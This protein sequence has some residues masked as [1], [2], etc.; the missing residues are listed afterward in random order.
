MPESHP[1]SAK[2]LFMSRSRRKTSERRRL[3][4]PGLVMA[5]ALT[6]LAAAFLAP[7][8]AYAAVCTSTQPSDFNGDGYSDAAV[9]DPYATVAGISQAGRVVVLYGDGDGRIGEGER[10]SVRQGFGSVVGAPETSDRFG[11]AIAIADINGDGCHDLVVGSPYENVGANSDSGLVQVV[12][13]DPGG[14]GAGALSQQLTQ[15][16]FGETV[17]AGDQFGYAV[18][19]LDEVYQ[20]GTGPPDAYALGIGAPGFDVA[21]HNDAGW[22][23]FVAATD[24]G[25]VSMDATQNTP[26]IPG[27]A[28][29]GDRFGSAISIGYLMGVGDTVDAAVGVPGE[30]V[31]A[32]VDAGSVTILADVYDA[33]VAGTDFSQN[34]PGVAS[35]AE[36]GDKFG[37]SLDTVEAAPDTSYL[38][39]GVPGE[40]VGA[41]ANA[42]MVQVFTTIN[43]LTELVP[44]VGLSQDSPGVTGAAE[45]GDLFGQD[46]EFAPPGPGNNTTRLAIS[47]PFEDGTKVNYGAIWIFP[48]NNLTGETTYSQSSTGMPGGASDG[49]RFGDSLAVVQGESETALLI[50]V[51]NDVQHSHGMVNVLPFGGAN[52]RAWIPGIDGVPGTGL[53]RFGAALASSAD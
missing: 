34:S 45:A 13:G 26:G 53:S 19:A 31:G 52:K 25:H 24:G 21:G 14:L 12:W 29:A 23:A 43:N 6:V 33:I 20:G 5:A 32:V 18:D 10:A 51:P 46:V 36:A 8:P 42:G 30:D 38:V 35:G 37:R 27:A 17:H 49:D 39:A 40:D 2:R 4:L 47:A 7:L 50:G 16:T 1:P 41:E 28:E 22:T 9:A 3:K 44:L 15:V 11:Y 48:L